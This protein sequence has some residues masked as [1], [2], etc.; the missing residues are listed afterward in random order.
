MT[1][2]SPDLAGLLE[3]AKNYKWTEEEKEK[4]R[5]SFAYGNVHL[6]NPE[7]THEMIAR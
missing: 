4:H 2:C 3:L 7:V 5:L 1:T 6:H